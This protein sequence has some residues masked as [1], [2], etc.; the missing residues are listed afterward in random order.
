MN[1]CRCGY[2]GV[3]GKSCSRAP[4]CAEEYQSKIS[5]P[6]LDRIDLQIEVPL[7]SPWVLGQIK[8]GEDSATVLKR[9][10]AARAFQQKRGQAILNAELDGTQLE[11]TAN[12]S[13]AARK[14]LIQAA[15]KF[16]LSGRGFHRMIRLSR[17]IADMA[18][19]DEILPEHISEA[20]AYR[21]PERKS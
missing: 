14:L 6:L 19:F 3:P 21:L 18:F 16:Q 2:L 17:T 15:E 20:L 5:G 8:E 13:D 9:V 1:P 12:L 7:L 11:Q 4:R 10:L